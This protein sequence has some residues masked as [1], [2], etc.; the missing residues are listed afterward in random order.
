MPASPLDELLLRLSRHEEALVLGVGSSVVATGMRVRGIST[1]VV[2]G[3]WPSIQLDRRYGVAVVEPSAGPGDVAAAVHCGAQ[4]VVPGGEIVVTLDDADAVADRFALR[5]L[6]RFDVEGS[7]VTLLQR[8]E[9]S[10]IHDKVFAARAR[11]KRATPH[12]LAERLQGSN[13]PTVVDTRTAVD[14]GRF[15]AIAGSIHVPRTLVEWH[16]DPANGYRHPEVRSFDQPLVLVCNG[17][18]SSSLAAASL[19]DLGFTDV[20]D[21]VG[22]VRAW[23]E[24][25]LSVVEPDHTHLDL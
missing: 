3:D 21:L 16:L 22:G 10:T 24:A 4:H 13:A 14:R 20:G 1:D 2:A 11:I 18:Y 12:E 6:R 15:G 23:L 17:G 19:L 7:T 25:G 8:T 9:R 5:V